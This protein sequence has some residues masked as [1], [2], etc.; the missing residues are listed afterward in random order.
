VSTDWTF[1]NGDTD[2]LHSLDEPL[3]LQILCSLASNLAK[4]SPASNG[5]QQSSADEAQSK[6]DQLDLL[7][8]GLPVEQ[9]LGSHAVN[10]DAD[11][12]E[13]WVSGLF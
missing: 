4:S 11:E 3:H 12:D 10:D 7:L 13:G 6:G 1:S 8:K 9:R 5:S 2:H